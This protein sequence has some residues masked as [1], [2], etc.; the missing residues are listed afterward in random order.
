VKKGKQKFWNSP[1]KVS[2]DH[3]FGTYCPHMAGFRYFSP[4]DVRKYHFA[5][6]PTPIGEGLE[7]GIYFWH[8]FTPIVK[9]LLLLLLLLVWWN[10]HAVCT[11]K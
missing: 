7:L 5:P 8:T 11:L 3:N 10:Q 1:Y 9:F 2:G 4:H 6:P